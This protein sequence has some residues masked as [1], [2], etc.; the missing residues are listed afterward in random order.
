MNDAVG[1]LDV[2]D[3]DL[4]VFPLSSVSVMLSPSIL[5]LILPPETVR[6]GCAP[7]SSLIILA[8]AA[9]VASVAKT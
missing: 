5:A 9:L 7:L 8:T 2:G 4:A 6:M 1:L 3:R